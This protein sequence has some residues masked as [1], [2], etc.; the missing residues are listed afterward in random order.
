[1]EELAGFL[2]LAK[3]GDAKQDEIEKQS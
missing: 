1:V 3:I 2:R